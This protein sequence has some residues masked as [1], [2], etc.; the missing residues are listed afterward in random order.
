MIDDMPA[1][2]QDLSRRY[3]IPA[4]EIRQAL[5]EKYGPPQRGSA[6]LELDDDRVAY[7]RGRFPEATTRSLEAVP[8]PELLGRYAL[9][10]AELRA[11]DVV[12]TANAPIGDYAEYLAQRV[13][14]GTLASNSVKSYDLLTADNRHIQVKAR[15]VGRSAKRTTKF[16]A[17][18]SFHFDVAS[19]LLFDASSY[20]LLWAREMTSEQAKAAAR[21][22][23]HVNADFLTRSI[24]ERDGVDV[25]ERFRI[26]IESDGA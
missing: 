18:R 16:S 21:H 14:G 2:I 8:T 9:I 3:D 23:D 20:A 26:A 15:A 7:V 25:T 12:R 1:T 19:F 22:S 24:V 10:L 5:R 13:Y 6:T 17:F 4:A 11:R